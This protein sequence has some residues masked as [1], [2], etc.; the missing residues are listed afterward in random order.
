MAKIKDTLIKAKHS[1]VFALS[2]YRST[3]W[4]PKLFTP[5]SASE[6]LETAEGP[7]ETLIFPSELYA[8]GVN[9]RLQG[10]NQIVG[11][12]F[13][14]E[15]QV[16]LN[17]MIK[18]DKLQTI[19]N[20]VNIIIELEKILLP[21]KGVPP[22]KLKLRSHILDA[23]S[24][25][26]A[27]A[28]LL[29]GKLVISEQI[30]GECEGLRMAGTIPRVRVQDLYLIVFQREWRMHQENQPFAQ[31]VH[32]CIDKKRLHYF[33]FYQQKIE[34]RRT[35]LPFVNFTKRYREA[36]L[37]LKLGFLRTFSTINPV[38]AEFNHHKR[39]KQKIDA[40]HAIVTSILSEEEEETSLQIS[41]K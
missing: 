15:E 11:V 41:I 21:V 10:L 19:K 8:D 23:I 25:L 7:S 22:L 40:N 9:K 24:Q 20:I 13:E 2:S 14:D 34:E 18:Y 3:T 6:P 26:E 30:F 32:E 36:E 33:N 29:N 27:A 5:A 1:L 12:A 35:P 17:N 39:K 38:E 4:Q 31:M 16:C 37:L 28:K